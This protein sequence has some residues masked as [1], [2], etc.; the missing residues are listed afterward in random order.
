VVSGKLLSSDLKGLDFEVSST[1]DSQLQAVPQSCGFPGQSEKRKLV[2]GGTNAV[3]MIT[4]LECCIGS[5]IAVTDCEGNCVKSSLGTD[6][7]L[8]QPPLQP[9]QPLQRQAVE[10]EA[11]ANTVYIVDFQFAAGTS[12]LDCEDCETCDV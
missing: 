8:G 7:L 11:D 9:L 3:I 10:F 1:E 12:I 6:C 4:M 5:Q 2:V